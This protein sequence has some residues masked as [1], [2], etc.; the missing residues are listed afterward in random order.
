MAYIVEGGQAFTFKKRDLYSFAQAH[1]RTRKAHRHRA[2]PWMRQ[3]LKLPLF[4]PNSDPAL[5]R[6]SPKDET[7]Q[8]GDATLGLVDLRELT[9]DLV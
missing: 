7:R 3:G 8:D 9:C 4:I 5:P 6:P 2:G 1:A